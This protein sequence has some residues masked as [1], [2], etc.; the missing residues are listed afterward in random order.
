MLLTTTV[1][2]K[3]HGQEVVYN[4]RKILC[5]LIIRVSLASSSCV[6]KVASCFASVFN[7]VVFVCRKPR[8]RGRIHLTGDV[9]EG[10]NTRRRS[11]IHKYAC[12]Y[13]EFLLLH[14]NSS[15]HPLSLAAQSNSERNSCRLLNSC[16]IWQNWQR[17]WKPCGT[18]WNDWKYH[19]AR[20]YTQTSSSRCSN[21]Y[22]WKCSVNH[23][24]NNHFMITAIAVSL[25][26]SCGRL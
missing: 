15:P 8:L 3:K 5:H 6:G 4:K 14:A 23:H 13:K 20:H 25:S 21:Q 1:L 11:Q 17:L 7:A 9:L 2:H 26:Q 16:L 19:N 10:A 12:N 22:E 24:S 18:S